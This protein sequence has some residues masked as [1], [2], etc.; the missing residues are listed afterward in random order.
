MQSLKIL[1]AAIYAGA[2]IFVTGQAQAAPQIL[3]HHVPQAVRE[4]RRLGSLAPEKRLDLAIGLPVRNSR[5]LDL[6]LEQ[7][8]DPAS[9]NYRQYLSPDQFIERFGP[10]QEDYDKL[11]AFFQANGFTIAATHANRM[12]LDVSGPV[13]AIE[14]TLHVN[15]ANW[16]HPSRG[17]F[18]APDRDP[19]VDVDVAVLDV[20]GLDNFVQPRPMDVKTMPLAS[21]T[22]LVSGSG[23]SGLY[24]GKDFRAAYAPSVTRTGAGQSIGLFELDGFYASDVQANFK[25][26]GLPV[27]PVQTVLLDGFNGSPGSGNVE[28]ILDIMMAAYMAPGASIIVYEGTNWND[29]LNRM[30]TDNIAKQLSSS[31]CF[32]PINTTTEQI[33]KQMIAQG[34]SLFQAS[35]DSGAYS[36]WIMPPADDPNLTVVGGTALTTTGPGGP[37]TS[38]SAWSG[39]GGGVS[40]TYAIPSYQLGMNLASRGGSNTMRNIPDVALTAAIQM[41]LIYSNGQETA[42]GGTSAAA[43]LW[44]GFTALANEQA[45]A[46]GKPAVGFLNPSLYALGSGSN[47]AASLH[48]I[49]SGSNGFAAIAGFDLATGW[50]TP[51]GQPL[52]NYLSSAS[53]ATPSFSLSA[54]PSSVSVQAASSATATVQVTPQNG[55][56]GAVTLTLAGIP[57]GVTGTLSALNSSGASTLTLVASAN[58]AAAS[59]TL[60]VTGKSGSLTASIA[61]PLTVKAGPSFTLAAAPSTISIQ[62][63]GSATST[64]SLTPQ[65]GFTGSASFAITGLPAGVTGSFSPATSGTST[66]L[67]LTASSSAT[68][69]T[70]TAVITATSGSISATASLSLTI[71]PPPNFKLSSS[72]ANIN[73]GI[74]GSAAATVSVVPQTGFTGTVA[75]SVTGLPAGVTAA[76]SPASTTGSSTITIKTATSAVAK[77]S[78]ITIT[79]I[80]GSLTSSIA[81][82]VTVTPPPDFAVA[83]LPASLTLVEGGKGS[84]AVQITPL[85]GF[86]G[87]VTLSTSSLPTGVTA[88][89]NTSSGIMLAT[90]SAAS[91]A[92]AGTS[93][94]TVTAI[95]GALSHA[96]LLNLTVAAASAGTVAVDLSPYYN[97]FASAVDNVPFTNGGLDALGHSYSGALLG[98]SHAIA[99]TVFAQGPMG[100]A[101]AVSG[102]A[103]ILPAG[104]FTTLKFLATGVNGN[105]PNQTFT[106]TYTD[107]STSSFT[108]SLS[109]WYTPQNYSG[110]T[111][112]I[113]TSYRDNS[114]GTIDGRIFYVYGYSFNL[115][116][117]K[118]IKS[119]ALPSNRNVV[120]L[121]V[122]LAGSVNLAAAAQVDL[123]KVFNGTGITSDARP[124]TGGLDGVG[125]AYSGSLLPAT[126]VFNNVAFQVGSADHADVVSGFSSAIALPAGKYSSLLVVGTGV[127]GSQLGQVFKV[128]YTD[129]TTTTFAQNLSDWYAPANFSG[130]SIALSMP[131]RNASTGLKDNR[132]FELYQYTFTLNNTKTVS[133]VSLPANAN[134]KVFAIALKQ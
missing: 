60:T 49:T 111:Q 34:Q 90:F 123:S 117:A 105:Q 96:V 6:L 68:V 97:V 33:F 3:P 114:T 75:L 118:T 108:Q 59:T 104:Q 127:N 37:W 74:G 99:G 9:P 4:S 61:I 128:T 100:V 122:T 89:F 40:T 73:V 134:V 39:S 112:A 80:S 81:M 67:K 55:F 113:T 5:G 24:I 18:F 62:Q 124:F 76:F 10:T 47:Y 79:G 35:G 45:A 58:A 120:V 44:A 64:I 115:N 65:N 78:Q 56:S 15:M 87:S 83:L 52:I 110:E 82:T 19:F 116:P 22:P 48:D 69:A 25:Q 119:I 51:A 46:N 41:F 28:V 14:S 121:A 57:S 125:Y 42:I 86:A 63:G 88:S 106:V 131:Y 32:S 85:N 8:T 27:V 91:S 31:W 12:I 130:E 50:G 43:P 2:I 17:E 38:E 70:S 93:Q 26:A 98:A 11:G 71:A 84:S 103:V 77:A 102:G 109:D 129:G 53:A 36:G 92:A 13:S 101:D 16:E 7:L 126:L 1:S 54:S 29:V 30:A 133:S 21:A 94:V 132:P 107:G 95:S 72:V 20:T 66:S 23:P